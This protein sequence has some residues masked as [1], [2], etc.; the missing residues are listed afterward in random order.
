MAP[1]VRRW[2]KSDYNN[3]M[4]SGESIAQAILITRYSALKA[5]AAELLE[6][7]LV[8][9]D[10]ESNSLY[11]YREQVCLI[12][13]STPKADYLVD[14]LAVDDLSPLEGL[15]ASPEI[16]KVFH[17]AE[18]DILCLRRDF[19]FK[20]NNLF[21][22]MVAARIL[23]IEAVGLGSLLEA[24]FG[25]QQDKRYQRA[26]WGQRPLPPPLIAYAQLDTHYL[27]PLR[28]RLY[29]QLQEKGLWPLA[30]E[31]F[32]RMRNVNGRD[33]EERNGDCW[34]IPGVHDLNPQQV[35]VLKEL[36]S[37]RD[38]AARHVNR[39]LF[40]VIS[41]QTLVAIA[42]HLPANTKELRGLPGMT[43]GQISRHG[44]ALVSAVERGLQ[45]SPVYP[46]QTRRPDEDVLE[47]MEAL[48]N[49]RK[50]TAAEMGVKSDIILPRDLLQRLAEKNPRSLE[51]VAEIMRD[52]PWRMENFGEEILGLLR[53]ERS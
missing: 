22:T 47:R 6:E 8:A 51:E 30:L 9:V 33:P 39:P 3:L 40:K 42:S 23:G 26:N 50:A 44:V 21:D 14:P 46:P 25:V 29:A 31:D 28:Q 4:M 5:L 2:L 37:Y 32:N 12:Q 20:F 41:D 13:F 10:T 53:K 38:K 18:Y 1:R 19:G 24:E 45:A 27:I 15:F 11:A 52:V 7:P 36:C 43:S 49:W 17:A 16:E 48:R 35:A 34:R